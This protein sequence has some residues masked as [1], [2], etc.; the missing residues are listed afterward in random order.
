[1]T[2]NTPPNPCRCTLGGMNWRFSHGLPYPLAST[3]LTIDRA[4]EVQ[5]RFNSQIQLSDWQIEP[6][7]W[8]F[9]L[10]CFYSSYVCQYK[11]FVQFSAN[12]LRWKKKTIGLTQ[13]WKKTEER[14]WRERKA[15]TSP[16][17]SPASPLLPCENKTQMRAEIPPVSRIHISDL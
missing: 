2:L 6:R 11:A 17:L 10:I 4:V 3:P 8:I 12:G 9:N 7:V 16:T 1:M 15:R 14:A 13:P 5:I